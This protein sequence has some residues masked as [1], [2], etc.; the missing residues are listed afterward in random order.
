MNVKNKLLN[1]F[2]YF[3]TFTLIRILLN[4]ERICWII[5]Q[6]IIHLRIPLK[7]FPSFEH[8]HILEIV[9]FP[10]TIIDVG[11]N[12][13]QFSSLILFL[14]KSS[15]VYA[16][17]PNKGETTAL[18]SR[19]KNIFPKRFKFYN[20]ALG[21]IEETKIFNL[22]KSSDNNSFLK[23][24]KTN[25]N[26]YSKVKLTG[27]NISV[28]IK[29]LSAFNLKMIGINN[30]LKIDVQGYELNVLKGISKE[31]Y[32]Q[33][34]WIYIEVSEMELYSGQSSY[35]EINS[36]LNNL[37]YE[38]EKTYNKILNADKKKIIYCDALYKN[39]KN[40]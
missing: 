15:F 9:P 14:K 35:R 33:I 16:F 21:D 26:L 8:K 34:Q 18:G 23:P 38:L 29:P 19:L 2:K 36:Y 30:L 4:P 5:Y 25:S 27:K 12:K 20:Y 32:E 37:G 40:I 10:K 22:A 1:I 11:F 31:L 24:T 3:K 6:K 39:I 13:G 7:T 17:D 28:N